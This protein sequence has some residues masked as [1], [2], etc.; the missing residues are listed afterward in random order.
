MWTPP[1]KP[2]PLPLAPSAPRD[3][4]SRFSSG[5]RQPSW[6]WRRHADRSFNN[7]MP[8]C[9]RDTSPRMSRGPPP[10]LPTAV[11]NARLA[12]PSA[13]SRK[14][15]GH[16]PS[17]FPPAACQPA[18]LPAVALFLDPY[19]GQILEPRLGLD[20]SLH[21][22]AQGSGVQIM[23]NEHPG[24]ILYDDLMH[25]RQQLVLLIEVEFQ[26]R[27]L[28]QPVHLG[29]AIGHHVRGLGRHHGAVE[30]ARKAA[31]GVDIP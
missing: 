3:L 15:V 20:K 8:S 16:H 7:R 5:C 2:V 29:I 28:D 26:L 4:L 9:A 25:L 18:G 14:T 23:H 6:T 12:G 31:E 11:M 22:G 1:W 21:L 13:L 27:G 10:I 19:G 24:G 30:A 17:L